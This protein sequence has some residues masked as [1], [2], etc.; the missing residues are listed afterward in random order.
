M[1]Q[2]QREVLLFCIA[3]LDHPLQDNEYERH[4]QW[5]GSINDQWRYRV[6]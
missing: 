2:I 3:L 6:A 4:D 5:I 1:G